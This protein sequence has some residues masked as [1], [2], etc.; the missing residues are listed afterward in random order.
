MGDGTADGERLADESRQLATGGATVVVAT[1]VAQALSMVVTLW[2]ARRLG[3]DD[4]GL[5]SLATSLILPLSAVASLGLGRTLVRFLPVHIGNK[6]DAQVAGVIS[7]SL[8]MTT[9]ASMLVALVTILLAEPIAEVVFSDPRLTPV[10]RVMALSVP[11]IVL[12][13][14]ALAATRGSKVMVF[15]A[16]VQ[17]AGPIFKTVA[18]AVG[19][20]VVA[21]LLWAAVGATLVQWLLSAIL[22]VGFAYWLYK[23][24]F[25]KGIDWSF[26]PLWIYSYPLILSTLMYT[27]A[28]RMDRLVLGV[29][30]DTRSVGIYSLAASLV[31]ILNLA[32]ASVV[33]TFLPIVADAHNRVSPERAQSLYIFVTRWDSRL[34]FAIVAASILIAPE[35]LAVLGPSYAE[36]LVPFIILALGVYISTIPGP[37]GAFLQ[38]TNHQRVDAANAVAFFVISPLIQFGLALWLGWIGVAV[39]VLVVAIVLNVVQTVEIYQIYHFHPFQQGHLLFS[40]LSMAILIVCALAGVRQDLIVRLALFALVAVGFLAY[41]YIDRSPDDAL[42]METIRDRLGRRRHKETAN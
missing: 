40:I 41:L 35:M 26:K 42:F 23:G 18:W 3:P 1:L 19:L 20:L 39:G 10:L 34:T 37:T 13:N 22:A 5:L 28:P 6:D 7:S 33:K 16:I 29:V 32:H 21:N 14:N 38:M 17:I 2:I 11:L 4:Y 30:A 25:G 31:V 12:T 8:V 24:Y 27:L 36:A 9:A 15:D